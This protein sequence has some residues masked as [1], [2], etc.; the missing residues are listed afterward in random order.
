MDGRDVV[1]SGLVLSYT[2]ITGDKDGIRTWAN[3][4]RIS[5]LVQARHLKSTIFS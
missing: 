3:F 4:A 5:N 1:A 2:Y